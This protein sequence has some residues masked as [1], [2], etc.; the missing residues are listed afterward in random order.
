MTT[1]TWSPDKNEEP[2]KPLDIETLKTIALNK[3]WLNTT[4][5]L[6]SEQII[7]LK[8]LMRQEKKY[9]Q[10]CKNLTITEIKQLVYFFTLIEEKYNECEAGNDSPV[11]ALNKLLKQKNEPLNKEDLLWIK[12]NS[13]NK[14]LP[15]GSIF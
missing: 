8:P 3:D 5:E 12:Q 11:I 4:P 13:R 10:S 9:W 15:N 14:F 6:T 2:T 1:E 7:W